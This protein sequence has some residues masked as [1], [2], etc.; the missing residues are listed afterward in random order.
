MSSRPKRL[1]ADCTQ[2]GAKDK[3][4]ATDAGVHNAA[5]PKHTAAHQIFRSV[6]I[7]DNHA[8][9]EGG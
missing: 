3:P 1:R 9:S 5:H 7:S 2:H 8:L 4:E 6:F